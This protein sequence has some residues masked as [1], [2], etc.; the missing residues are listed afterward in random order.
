MLSLPYR[1]ISV[2]SPRDSATDRTALRVLVLGGIISKR[3]N[4]GNV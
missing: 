4:M 1:T 3:E 2:P